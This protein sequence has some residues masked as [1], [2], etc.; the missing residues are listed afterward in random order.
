MIYT[1]K[2][3]LNKGET[4]YSIRNKVA[5]GSLYVVTRGV[6]SDEPDSYIDEFYYATR[7]PNAIITGISAFYIYELTDNIPDKIHVAS[8]QHSYPIRNTNIV[9]SYQEASFF[10]IGKTRIAYNDGYINIYDQERL[11]I[12]LIRLKEKYPKDLYY[13]VLNSFRKIKHKIDFYKINK[14]VKHFKNG[15]ALLQKIKELI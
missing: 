13:E 9:Q 3:L 15:D 7:Y 10:E 4:E 6:Y 12:E 11:L 8:E 5:S 1:T 2:E 14:Y